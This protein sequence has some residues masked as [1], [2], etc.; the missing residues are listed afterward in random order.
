MRTFSVLQKW[1]RIY[2][3]SFFYDSNSTQPNESKLTVMFAPLL[4]GWIKS[5]YMTMIQSIS[6]NRK[7]TFKVEIESY[8]TCPSV[9]LVSHHT[10]HRL[11]DRWWG[12]AKLGNCYPRKGKRY[13]PRQQLRDRS[14]QIFQTLSQ[15]SSSS[16]MH[17]GLGRS[18]KL[19]SL[20]DLS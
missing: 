20:W 2:V 13:V 8:A 1:V 4:L 16:I 9:T 7:G 3:K 10:D 6:K 19:L 5:Y 17:G 14:L 18:A 11:Q 12:C 15:S